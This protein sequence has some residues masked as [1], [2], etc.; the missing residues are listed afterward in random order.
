MAIEKQTSKKRI[1]TSYEKLSD[2]LLELFAQTYPHGYRNAVM[3]VTK[4]NG[5]IIYVVRMETE[6]VAYLVRVEV[7]IDVADDYEE[8][9]ND[10]YDNDEPIDA[11]DQIDGEKEEEESD[12]D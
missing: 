12:F 1:L 5:E 7:K 8:E 3:P 9:E 11:P 2:E 6:E 4:P 10:S